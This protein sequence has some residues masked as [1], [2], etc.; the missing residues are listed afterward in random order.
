[1]TLQPYHQSRTPER[2]GGP[3]TGE[4]V[5]KVAS[6]K[7]QVRSEGAPTTAPQSRDRDGISTVGVIRPITS[8]T[9]PLLGLGGTT[10]PRDREEELVNQMDEVWVTARR[11]MITRS[12]SPVARNI[13]PQRWE[14]L[15]Y[16]QA[17]HAQERVLDLRSARYSLEVTLLNQHLQAVANKGLTG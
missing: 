6:V 13:R 10:P 1:M 17:R 3:S 7:A 4:S 12:L 14:D 5:T 16:E 11:N 15:R 8:T 9:S 2:S